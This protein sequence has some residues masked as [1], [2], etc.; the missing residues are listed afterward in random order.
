MEN[1]EKQKNKINVDKNLIDISYTATLQKNNAAQYKNLYNNSLYKDNPIPTIV[2]LINHY[3]PNGLWKI[4]CSQLTAG[5]KTF[6]TTEGNL[7]E[8]V[9]NVVE[10]SL[11]DGKNDGILNI[12][13]YAFNNPEKLPEIKLALQG[14][15][16]FLN[17]EISVD[18]VNENLKD[19]PASEIN[20]Y[21]PFLD[22]LNE[23]KGED[24]LFAGFKFF[25]RDK[26]NALG[27]SEIST[28]SESINLNEDITD[29]DLIRFAKNLKNDLTD[30]TL[31][32]HEGKADPDFTKVKSSLENIKN[33]I[34][35]LIE[36]SEAE[37]NEELSD[38]DKSLIALSIVANM[39][40][41]D[42]NENLLAPNLQLNLNCINTSIFEN[43]CNSDI[44]VFISKNASLE[45]I[46]DEILNLLEIEAEKEISVPSVES[47]EPRIK[48]KI[49]I[50]D[51]NIITVLGIFLNS[52]HSHLFDD[53]KK[54]EKAYANYLNDNNYKFTKVELTLLN[55]INSEY[56]NNRFTGKLFNKNGKF[57]KN[58]NTLDELDNMSNK[59]AN[60]VSE[61]GHASRYVLDKSADI[62]KIKDENEL[63]NHLNKVF[64]NFKDY[65]VSPNNES[66]KK[67]VI[68]NVKEFLVL[69]PI[70]KEKTA[71]AFQ[72]GKT[73][74]KTYEALNYAYNQR[75]IL[76]NVV[77]KLVSQ[78]AVVTKDG[79]DSK[80]S[81][82]AP[83]FYTLV[84]NSLGYSRIYAQQKEYLPKIISD[85]LEIIKDSISNVEEKT[86]NNKDGLLDVKDTHDYDGL[87]KEVDDFRAKL[88]DCVSKEDNY[89][90]STDKKTLIK[91]FSNLRSEINE[92]D[93]VVAKTKNSV[94]NILRYVEKLL[95]EQDIAKLKLN[96]FF[97]DNYKEIINENDLNREVIEIAKRNNIFTKDEEK[98][99]SETL[100]KKVKDILPEDKKSEFDEIYKDL[101]KVKKETSDRNLAQ[102]YIEKI[103]F[104]LNKDEKLYNLL[105]EKDRKS[106]V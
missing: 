1:L 58:E 25:E 81:T 99:D 3:Q 17:D 35:L 6:N 75:K 13:N 22:A 76:K 73:I 46:A 4:F 44:S 41:I 47:L 21:I 89:V 14:L 86:K 93:E 78:N 56:L 60:Y 98:E 33:N 57:I 24:G 28:E 64:A 5:L 30:Y 10:E 67:F 97:K 51:K 7:S 53:K 23:M 19:I 100:Y 85:S 40:E 42:D 15:M 82:L 16:K 2:Y 91:D 66:I 80:V 52:M 63:I 90:K 48:Q 84:I 95:T 26:D 94:E 20:E 83:A 101:K 36:K 31:I 70:V 77:Y 59:F 87:K 37:V 34:D 61:F 104:A 9:K 29:E 65:N 12:L 50:K 102:Y 49:E 55:Y 43:E 71:E 105:R 45:E 74:I 79:K 68:E 96:K 8:E 54:F 27:L 39:I 72:E 106:V 11:K 88:N 32:N 103:A 92:Y 18:A 69:T 62:A 38:I